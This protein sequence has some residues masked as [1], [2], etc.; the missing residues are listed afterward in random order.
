MNEVFIRNYCHIL[1]LTSKDVT[2]TKSSTLIYLELYV[3][4]YN[5]R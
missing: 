1:A 3:L 5:K 2:V 4:L